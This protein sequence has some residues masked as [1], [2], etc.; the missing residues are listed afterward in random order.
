MFSQRQPPPSSSTPA[1]PTTQ[2][3]S[4]SLLTQFQDFSSSSDD[5]SENESESDDRSDFE[6]EEEKAKEEA[7]VV[8][9]SVKMKTQKK[10]T[11]TKTKKNRQGKAATAAG[12][13]VGGMT[14][15]RRCCVVEL[16]SKVVDDEQRLQ[17][18]LLHEV[19]CLLATHYTIVISTGT[20]TL[21][22]HWRYCQHC[23]YQTLSTPTTQALTLP[24]L[25]LSAPTLHPT[26]TNSNITN[27]SCVTPRPGWWM[28]LASP[29]TGP[30]S[31]G[32]RTERQ[33]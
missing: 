33:R 2:G 26:P 6:E 31:T 24:T 9:Q 19:V 11:K 20:S 10:K 22:Q 27:T 28:G 12:V 8:G 30:P 14:T 29:R 13:A 1:L 4:V 15:M 16:A 3:T 21:S 23:H 32:G 18:T 25:T 7:V 5:D 17:E